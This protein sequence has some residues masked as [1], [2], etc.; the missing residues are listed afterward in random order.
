MCDSNSFNREQF[1]KVSAI[2]TGEN[3][4]DLTV[5]TM[6]GVVTSYDLRFG[7]VTSFY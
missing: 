3:A 4:Y 5:G 1:G 2:T 7:L 6:N